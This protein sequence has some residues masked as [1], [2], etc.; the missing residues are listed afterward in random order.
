VSTP[1]LFS[2]ERI[3]ELVVEVADLLGPERAQATVVLVG[4]SLLA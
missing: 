4:G 2:G 1:G 3:R